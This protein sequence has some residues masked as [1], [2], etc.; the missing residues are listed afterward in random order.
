MSLG[1]YRVVVASCL[2]LPAWVGAQTVKP[3]PKSRTYVTA[4][5]Y[6]EGGELHLEHATG[7]TVQPLEDWRVIGS[8]IGRLIGLARPAAAGTD[9]RVIDS[10]GR[11]V[12]T[13]KVPLGDIGII[14]DSGIV[15]LVEA[16]HGPVRPHEVRFYSLSGAL[17]REVSEPKLSLVKWWPQADGRM[18]TVGQGPGPDERTVIVYAADGRAVWRYVWNGEGYPDVAVTPDNQRLVLLQQDTSG[19]TAELKIL[20]QRNRVLETHRLP[21]LY[22]MTCS[23]DSRRIA[24]VGQQV[25]V[26]LDARS[27]KLLW[28][29]DEDIDLVLPGGLRFEPATSSLLIVAAKRDRRAEVSRLSLRGLDLGTAEV[30][31]ADLGQGPLDEASVVLDV[32][33][34]AAG[35]RRVVL[36][37]RVVNTPAER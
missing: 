27:G 31:R 11:Q 19:G 32:A 8:P 17:L 25:A 22:Q 3:L 5:V 12:G 10:T 16:L 6:Q 4:E 2:L 7:P 26:L 21:N 24:A 28:R 23:E 14:T 9:I 36:H 37:D 18:V 13:A 20:A 30:R 33:P 35:E 1:R 15:T 29:V 34:P